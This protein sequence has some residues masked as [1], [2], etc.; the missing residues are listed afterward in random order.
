MFLLKNENEDRI[1]DHRKETP[2]VILKKEAECY[3]FSNGQA[4]IRNWKRKGSTNTVN[5]KK[6]RC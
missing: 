5:V 3:M 4:N 1:E 6:T 2:A